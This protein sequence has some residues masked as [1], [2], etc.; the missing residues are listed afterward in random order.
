MLYESF[1]KIYNK[2]SDGRY[3]L[4]AD[5]QYPEKLHDLDNDLPFY[6]KE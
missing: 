3:F 6:L 5:V 4:E 2:E 1:I